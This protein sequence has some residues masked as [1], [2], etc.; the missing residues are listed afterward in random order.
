MYNSS[1]YI[2]NEKTSKLF[3]PSLFLSLIPKVPQGREEEVTMNVARGL[4]DDGIFNWG[5]VLGLFQLAYKVCKK[6]S[7]SF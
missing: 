6:V 2:K 7:S 4:F 1:Y 3:N 5:R